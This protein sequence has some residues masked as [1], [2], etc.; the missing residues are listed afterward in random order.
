MAGEM[1]AE[2]AGAAGD[3]NC[4]GG[5][6]FLLFLFSLP[7]ASRLARTGQ[8]HALKAMRRKMGQ[9]MSIRISTASRGVRLRK[10]SLTRRTSLLILSE[11]TAKLPSE[12]T[13]RAPRAASW[14]AC[15]EPG[16]RVRLRSC[17]S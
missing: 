9:R 6:S 11:D 10:A 4:H 3:Q 15:D 7:Y 17:A 1:A 16:P 13:A 12:E 14:T 5:P 2:K 8:P